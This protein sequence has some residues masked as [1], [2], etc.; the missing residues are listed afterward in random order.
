MRPVTNMVL[1][2]LRILGGA[3]GG[4]VRLSRWSRSATSWSGSGQMPVYHA[5][6][7]WMFPFFPPSSNR[8]VT[9]M[10]LRYFMLL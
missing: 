8:S 5:Q 4:R 6:P 10:R 9:T 1:G 2:S 3:W 7:F